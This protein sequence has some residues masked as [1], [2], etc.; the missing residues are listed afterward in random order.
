MF[1]EDLQICAA[2]AK[3]QK[4]YGYPKRF[5]AYAG[6]N[7]PERVIKAVELLGGSW[8]MGSA[9]QS[10]DPDVLEAIKRKNISPEKLLGFVDYAKEIEQSMETEIAQ[11]TP[12]L[13]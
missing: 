3:I 1:K 9:M 11:S 13:V 4:T 10:T 6:K 8:S 12:L 7:K 5:S 2:I